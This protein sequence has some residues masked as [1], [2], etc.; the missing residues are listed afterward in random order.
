MQVTTLNRANNNGFIDDYFNDFF[1]ALSLLTGEESF[2][3]SLRKAITKTYQARLDY[4]IKVISNS[5]NIDSLI[6]D[7]P[8]SIYPDNKD[9]IEYVEDKNYSET[10]NS[11]IQKKQKENIENIEYVLQTLLDT[12]KLVNNIVFSELRLIAKD[13]NY[14]VYEFSILNNN[15][16]FKSLSFSI[17]VKF[18]KDGMYSGWEEI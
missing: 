16:E 9:Y 14:H 4:M 6:S 8:T 10:E 5:E 2:K 18:D 12:K 15:E 3:E 11:E 1:N 13:E 17:K 7:P